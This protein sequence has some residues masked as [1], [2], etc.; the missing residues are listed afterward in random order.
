MKLYYTQDKIS[1]FF[2]QIF[3]KVFPLSVPHLKNL[4]SIITAM[5]D[6]ESVVTA[7][8]ARKFKDNFYPI[9]LS[10]L[11]R[12][13][14]RF[15][16]S[17]SNIAY[18]F[19]ES[20]IQFI[21]SKYRIKH[22][23]KKVH[24]SF[25]HMFCKDKFTV[26]LFSLRLG[27]QGI[28]LW[29][30]CFKGRH[31]TDAY[32]LDLIK[33]GI[34]FCKNLFPD[35][36]HIIFLADR[37]FVHT[38]ILSYI[39]NINAF[40]C[41]RTKSFFTFSYFDNNQNLCT[42]HLRDIKPLKYSGKYFNDILFT[43]KFF[44]TNLVVA[45]AND[46]GDTW[47]LVTNDSPNRAVRNY[48]YR[49]GSIESIFKNQKHNGFRLESTNTQKI[50][51]FI[52]LFTIMCVA[53]VWLTIIGIDYCKNKHHYSLNIRDSRKLKNGKIIRRYSFFRLGLTIFNLVYY[54]YSSFK[55]KFDFL[56]YD[57]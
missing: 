54:N 32:K 5:I 21:I 8:I 1:S 2:K 3:K 52:S 22:A 19:Y 26:L 30:R 25:D 24:I 42:K 43:R 10:S 14:M 48:S 41:I 6:A 20:L 27:K 9:L 39:Q 29:F 46:S 13:F 56:L 38:E 44:K 28:P 51:N 49:F 34:L 40:Y 45:K 53:L 31:N 18:Q 15:F 55:L 23:D 57:I 17:F 11:E 33:E 12:R 4:S 16:S 35:D 36:C 50:E 7:D 37:W 47:Y